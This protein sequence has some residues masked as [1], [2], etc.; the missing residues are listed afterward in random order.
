[1]IWV[2]TLCWVLVMVLPACTT[3]KTWFPDKE[4]NYQFQTEISALQLPEDIR[5]RFQPDAAAQSAPPAAFIVPGPKND[6]RQPDDP[7]DMR[8][9]EQP[10][11]ARIEYQGGAVGLRI[12]EGMGYSWRLVGKGLSRQGVEIVARNRQAGTYL[13]Y[14]QPDSK[15]ASDESFMDEIRFFLGRYNVGSDLEMTVKLVENP[16]KQSVDVLLVNNQMQPDTRAQA[17]ELIE[18]LQTTLQQELAQ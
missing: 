15:N 10:R 2:Q 3:I 18:L 9:S 11:M 4:K 14:Y 1:M 17:L 6:L 16:A 12:Y 8:L 5:A 7:R 13:I